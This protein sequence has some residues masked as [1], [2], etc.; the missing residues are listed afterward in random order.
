MGTQS[1]EEPLGTRNLA[2]LYGLDAIPWSRA[3]E[4]L[5]GP[6]PPMVTWFLATT[7][8]TAGRT[9]RASGGLVRRQGLVRERRDPQ[10]PEP[11]RDTP[12]ARSRSRCRDRPRLRR[13][14]PKR[15]TDEETLQRL[16]KRAANRLAAKVEDGAFTYD[17]P[18]R[19][20]GRRRGTPHLLVDADDRHRRPGIEPGGATRWG[21]EG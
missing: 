5:Q 9:S 21:F 8:L 2:D 19:A 17:Y 1:R 12:P 13:E 7:R 4:A 11:G 14:L 15:V 3:L 10:E 6:Q 18:R 16:A 20:P